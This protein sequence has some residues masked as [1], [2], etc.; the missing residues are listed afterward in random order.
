MPLNDDLYTLKNLALT[1]VEDA[2]SRLCLHPSIFTIKDSR[3]T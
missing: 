2:F 3:F 1:S